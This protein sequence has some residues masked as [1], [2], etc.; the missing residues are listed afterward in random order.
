MAVT[1]I[2]LAEDHAVVRQGVRTLLQ[3]EPDFD[4]V[5]EAVDGRQA[6]EMLE[7]LQPDVLVLDMVMP[8][9][10]GLEVLRRAA[11]RSPRTRAVVL[12]MHE[13][14]AYV[15]EALAAGASA[16]VLKR[17]D[18][19]VLA[20]AIREAVAGRRYLS[21]PLSENLI[22]DYISTLDSG[23]FDPYHT[24]TARER[25]VLMLVA[26]G[27]SSAEIAG[28]LFL[29]PRTVEMHRANAMRK[30]GL[31]SQNDLIRYALRKGLALL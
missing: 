4:V 22:E 28:R 3:A 17:S 26:E 14:E 18:V 31:R 6:V 13:D 12:S 10:G 16:Y 9:L 29:S 23:R 30:L 1:T 11:Q 27:N 2:M 20:H 24:L 19:E 15:V 7:R 8:G 21:P 25:E 5:G